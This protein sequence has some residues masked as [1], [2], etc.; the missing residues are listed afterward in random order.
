MR[1]IDHQGP[2]ALGTLGWGRVGM[3]PLAAGRLETGEAGSGAQG[4]PS[5]WLCPR[6]VGCRGHSSLTASGTS[7]PGS[8]HR[9]RLTKPRSRPHRASRV[10]TMA[11]ARLVIWGLLLATGVPAGA[12]GMLPGGLSPGGTLRRGRDPLHS[13]AWGQRWPR[14]SPTWEASGEL[15]GAGAPGSERWAGGSP[16]RWSPPLQA[17]NASGAPPETDTTMAGAGTGAWWDG[18]AQAAV[19]EPLIAWRGHEAQGQDSPRVGTRL[20]HGS[21][22]GTPS[23]EV[24]VDTGPPLAGQR[25]SPGRQG[26]TGP[27]STPGPRPTVSTIALTP[28]AAAAPGVGMA[29]TH[30]GG[31]PAAGGPTVALSL[32]PGVQLTPTSSR[33]VLL[34]TVPVPHPVGT[35][36]AWGPRASPGSVESVGRWGDLEEPPSPSPAL[37]GSAPWLPPA[38]PSWGLAEPWSRELPAHQ[39]STRRAP[40][41]HATASPGDTAPR[42]DPRLGGQQGPQPTPGT[43]LSTGPALPPASSTDPPGTPG[44]G[45]G[46]HGAGDPSVG[47][48]PPECQRPALPF[49]AGLLPEEDVGSPQQVRGAVVPPSAPNAT[50]A[51]PRPTAHPATGTPATRR[52]GDMGPP[53]NLPV[54]QLP[55]EPIPRV[56]GLVG[57]RGGDGSYLGP[58]SQDTVTPSIRIVPSDSLIYSCPQRLVSSAWQMGASRGVGREHGTPCTVGPVGDPGTCWWDQPWPPLLSPVLGCQG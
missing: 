47:T 51:A 23:P 53:P 26:A 29:G 40:L 58:P 57:R 20:P 8:H 36:P 46:R 27:A 1:G 3:G 6:A 14:L 35:G 37:P 52:S 50:E 43:A 28:T 21:V 25:P 12:Q 11:A 42:T 44:T 16:V 9:P 49:L 32:P 55:W 33:P 39:R 10:L 54:L 2:P 22:L 13:P 15:S 41:S 18:T 34:G 4:Q 7:P 5:R 17:G 31:Q 48:E 24:T 45:K 19:E 56:S 30:T 38:A